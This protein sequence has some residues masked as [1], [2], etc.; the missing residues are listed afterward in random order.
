[1]GDPGLDARRASCLRLLVHDLNNPLTA[2][3][4]L[5]EML[6]EEAEGEA[7]RDLQDVLEAADLATALVDGLSAVTHL[8]DGAGD[9]DLTWTHLDLASIVRQV[10]DRPAFRHRVELVLPSELPTHGDA[11]AL[12]RAI[13]DI[14]VNA[15]ALTENDATIRVVGREGRHVVELGVV[16]PPPVVPP[17]LRPLLLQPYGTVELRRSRRIP[18]SAMGL[19]YA[20]QVAERHDGT[21]DFGDVED[22]MTVL[23][24]LPRAL[25]L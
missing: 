2:I 16:H 22:G 10:V 4:I 8:E 15:R 21:V 17:D 6:G 25:R 24:R 18:A 1:M 3:R 23:L 19:A 5:A 13:T 11:R 14:L 7:R 12:Q 20:A 9:E